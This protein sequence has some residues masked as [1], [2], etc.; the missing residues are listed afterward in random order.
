MH[1]QLLG[2]VDVQGTPLT[3]R[4][5]C[6]LTALLLEPGRAVPVPRLL[7]A[8]WGDDQPSTPQNALRTQI[9]RL[10]RT[11]AD[12]SDITLATVGDGYSLEIDPGLVDLHRFRRL[13]AE[14]RT[15]DDPALTIQL[16]RSA[17]G[18]WQGA[19]L[20]GLPETPWW[21]SVRTALLAER[22]A[23]QEEL[24]QAESE[25]VAP[26]MVPHQLPASIPDFTGREKQLNELAECAETVV[27][28][29]IDGTAGVGKTALALHFAHRLP[30]R[31]PDGQLYVNLRGFDPHV[32]PLRP[33]EVLT[34]FLRALGIKPERVPISL[35]EQA[36]LY[37]T[38]LSD[39]RLLVLLDNA[40]D[41]DQVRPLLPGTESCLV[42][43][44]SRNRLA[45]LDAHPLFLDVLDPDE[46][47]ALLREVLG[48]RVDDEPAAAR[49]LARLCGYLPLALRIAAANAALMPIAD[50]VA[51]LREENRLAALA[52]EDDEQVAVRSAFDLSYKALRPGLRRVFRRLG[53]VP[54]LDFT[55]ESATCLAGEDAQLDE[56][57]AANLV[58]QHG[59]RYRLHDL[60]RLYAYDRAQTDDTSS[61]RRD[62]CQRLYDWYLSMT[63]QA[64]KFAGPEFMHLSE[65]PESSR[66]GSSADALA[67]L[68]S[69]R[70]NLVAVSACSP[71]SVKVL[72]ADHLHGFFKLG[73]HGADWLAVAQAA[74]DHAPDDR[75]RLTALH[76]LSNVHWSRG[77]HQKA[78]EYGEAALR[79]A[80]PTARARVLNS[81]GHVYR[82]IGDVDTALAYYT[83]AIDLNR[84][85]GLHDGLPSN[86]FGLGATCWQQGRLAEAYEFHSKAH[87]LAVQ[88]GSAYFIGFYL[89]VVGGPLRDLGDV[90]TAISHMTESV[91]VLKEH[92]A[93]SHASYMLDDLSWACRDAGHYDLALRTG[94]E[95]LDIALD[96]G[97]PGA[98][99]D[100]RTSI[101]SVLVL[102]GRSPEARDHFQRAITLARR[103]GYR[104]GEAAALIGLAQSL[105]DVV[106]ALQSLSIS[107]AVGYK[108]L[109][110]SAL[111]A[112]AEICLQSGDAD[113]ARR[114][115]SE[116][117][118]LHLQSGHHLGRIRTQAVIDQLS[119][120]R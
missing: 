1:I 34:Q 109:E 10:R 57:V 72:L 53:L 9:H 107:R 87:E 91:R 54:G 19:P 45:D 22:Q 27:I 61:D 29:A 63:L 108:L 106:P 113:Q 77:Q 78:I 48:E 114:Y 42:L 96:I 47:V 5:R 74:L 103:T 30:E 33:A 2:S 36:A 55:A 14:A 50:V 82:E 97:D 20:S 28:T 119:D 56:L 117:M 99:A 49:E 86:Y 46:A 18:L 16:L 76:N 111:T 43:I 24:A 102:T 81:L 75:G 95:A 67:W 23:A 44:T 41:A 80:W 13:L 79:I 101:A 11:L 90:E 71:P 4:Q 110:A 39:R 93:R 84:E 70:A 120:L 32:R 52:I 64:A 58:E 59:S 66:F 8:V 73:R 62:A 21:D 38:L 40:A 37:R 100:A 104:H 15:S 83:E 69:E 85:N 116:A 118:V 6:L 112:L 65:A 115:A 12:T 31:Y 60:L 26:T 105:G 98:E 68:E 92:G 17:L 35:D 51:E 94:H 7:A 3:T 25:P 89:G 88:D